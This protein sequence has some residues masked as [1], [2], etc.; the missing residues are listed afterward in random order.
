[1]GNNLFFITGVLR[2]FSGAISL[3]STS[4]SSVSNATSTAMS[5]ASSAASTAISSASSAA[6]TA[7]SSAS[8]V[9]S[10]SMSDAATTATTTISNAS[11]AATTES[12]SI[13][14][15]QVAQTLSNLSGEKVDTGVLSQ[16]F[17]NFPQMAFDWLVHVF[18][19]LVFVFI[20]WKL[21]DFVA[22]GFRKSMEKARVD[23]SMIHFLCLLF[24]AGLKMLLVFIVAAQLGINTSSIIAI[25][26]SAGVAIGLAVQGTL[27]NLAGGILIL[28][29][30]PFRLGD[31]IIEDTKGHEGTV[32]EISLF[33][34]K[35][36]TADNRIIIL[37]NGDLA[38]TSLTNSTKNKIRLLQV[39]VDI[40]YD[41][42]IKIAKRVLEKTM[43]NMD[44]T[45]KDKEC[46]VVVDNLG[47][48][49]IK[50]LLRCY[51]ESVNY[52]NAR[53]E[54]TEKAKL[55]LDSANIQIP[56]PQLDVHLRKDE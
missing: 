13:V 19:A 42:D 51:V 31:Y 33:T 23:E 28:L 24:T 9:A 3:A 46:R 21:I 7:I 15:E 22:K 38:N 34:T 12:V 16:F 25:L 39:S 45:L 2:I 14:E 32:Q 48:S 47:D 20:F 18:I 27:S 41:S 35:L 53:W 50:L 44:F 37:P 11:T 10:T 29:T 43:E 4:A 52:L 55:T 17:R 5:S 36:R 1:M 40:S 26:G 30:K 54:L 49:S 8:S 56:Y 6:S